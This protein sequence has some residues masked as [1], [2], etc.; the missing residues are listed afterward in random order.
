MF[1]TDLRFHPPRFILDTTVAGIRGSQQY[2][3]RSYPELDRLV[4]R[5]YRYR[6]TVDDIDVYERRPPP[7]GWGRRIG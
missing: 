3:M 5:H 4:R 7:T 2:P 1:L 6:T